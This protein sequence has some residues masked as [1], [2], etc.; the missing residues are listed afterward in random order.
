MCHRSRAN[1]LAGTSYATTTNAMLGSLLIVSLVPSIAALVVPPITALVADYN[2]HLWTN[3][4]LDA[5]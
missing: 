2:Q 5:L 1:S 4:A 3:L